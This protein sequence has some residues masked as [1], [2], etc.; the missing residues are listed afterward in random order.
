MTKMPK[1]PLCESGYVKGNLHSDIDY[2]GVSW[3]RHASPVSIE[4]DFDG[5]T[6]NKIGSI[7]WA[8]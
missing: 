3:P 7:R 6:V 1:L 5:K 4:L 8:G 2:I